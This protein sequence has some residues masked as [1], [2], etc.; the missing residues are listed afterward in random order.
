MPSHHQASL[1]QR[2]HDRCAALEWQEEW[3]KRNLTFIRAVDAHGMTGILRA[4]FDYFT[5]SHY[6]PDEWVSARETTYA[7]T[8]TGDSL[9]IARRQT[10]AVV[11]DAYTDYFDLLLPDDT[12]ISCEIT[13]DSYQPHLTLAIT[14]QDHWTADRTA[15][16]L[17]E[18]MT[19]AGCEPV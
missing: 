14:A 8:P 18:L 4:C 15:K 3:T 17:I 9:R 11:G 13:E 6:L 16:I 5:P 1:I 2:F 10:G 12:L 19:R 7:L